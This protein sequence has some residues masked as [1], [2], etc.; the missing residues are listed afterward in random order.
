MQGK[1]SFDPTKML[2]VHHNST[3]THH[4]NHQTTAPAHNLKFTTIKNAYC[5][6][7]DLSGSL[8]EG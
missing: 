8:H 2:A 4:I 3:A 5:R 1:A 6:R 7:A